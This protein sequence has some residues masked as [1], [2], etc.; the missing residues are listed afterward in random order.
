MKNKAGNLVRSFSVILSLQFTFF[1][2]LQS[3]ADTLLNSDQFLFPDFS[4]GIARTKN[5]EK[6]VLNMNY[7]I[8]TEKMV[9]LQNNQ[10]FDITNPSIIDTVYIESRKFIPHGKVFLEL[11]ASGKTQFL[12]QHTGSFKQPGRPAAYGGTSQVSSSTYINNLKLG[13]DVFRMDNKPDVVIY[14]SPLSWIRKDYNFYPVTSRKSILA[15]YADRKTELR[16]FVNKMKFD[17]KNPDLV[18]EVVEFYNNLP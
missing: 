3:Q 14:Y 17:P 12:V 13:N 11:V 8:V 15:I 1:S 7:N 4:V 18:R 5:G 6:T 2:D 10:I 16:S 9:F